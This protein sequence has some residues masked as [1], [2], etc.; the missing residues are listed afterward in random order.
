MGPE[1]SVPGYSS[2]CVPNSQWAQNWWWYL[3]S[4]GPP[5]PSYS[6]LVSCSKSLPW[7]QHSSTSS[8]PGQLYSSFST[9][10]WVSFPRKRSVYL[11]PSHFSP[12]LLAKQ[13]PIQITGI[14]RRM[15]YSIYAIFPLLYLSSN[16]TEL[17]ED[18][19]HILCIFSLTHFKGPVCQTENQQCLLLLSV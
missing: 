9:G 8:W 6:Y 3:P 19:V 10:L 12:P 13:Y 2:C 7:L 11:D 15:Q 5:H 4:H 17:C 16:S 14:S 18:R 1:S